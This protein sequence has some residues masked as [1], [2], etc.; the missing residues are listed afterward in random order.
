MKIGLTYQCITPCIQR[1][2]QF[3]YHIYIST[4]GCYDTGWLDTQWLSPGMDSTLISVLNNYHG[5]RRAQ[6]WYLHYMLNS[7]CYFE[8]CRM[9]WPSNA[10]HWM[11]SKWAPANAI[12][13]CRAVDRQP[14]GTFLAHQCWVW[15]SA[16]T[17]WWWVSKYWPMASLWLANPWVGEDDEDGK[18]IPPD[19]EVDWASTLNSLHL[20]FH[21]QTFIKPLL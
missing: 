14:L 11:L 15:D 18:V 6:Y 7:W 10:L 13:L 16:W 12:P 21:H 5:S 1:F 20:Y 19:G 4:K 3:R 9:Y 8:M 2:V 17:Q